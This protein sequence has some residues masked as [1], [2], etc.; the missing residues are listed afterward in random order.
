MSKF[1]LSAYTGSLGF[2]TLLMLAAG[3][4]TVFSFAP[5]HLWLLQ[6]AGPALLFILLLRHDAARLTSGRAFLLGWAYGFAALYAATHWLL[7]A[8]HRFGGMP[9]LLAVIA[10]AFLAAYLALFYGLFAASA[11]WVGRR[12]HPPRWI[13]ALLF[14]P[15]LWVANEW[16]RGFLFTGFPWAISG[17]AH[18]AS[19]LA[20]FAPVLGVLGLGWL[21]GVLAGMAALLFLNPDR[22]IRFAV[23]LAVTGVLAAG[24]WLQSVSWTSPSGQPLKISLLQGNI[25]QD[26][27][28]DPD[29]LEATLRLYHDMILQANADLIVTPETALPVLSSQLPPDYLPTLNAFA[30]QQRHA[31]LIGLAAHDG[32]AR[33]ANSVVGFSP[34]YAQ[35]AYRYDKHHLVPFGEF[36]P[37]GFRWFVN[38]MHIPLG[39]FTAGAPLQAAMH[40]RDQAVL[41]N[42]C[43]EDL[44]GE[45]IAAQLAAQADGAGAATILLNVSN[46]AWYGDSV[47]MP[48]HLQFS[49]MRVLETGRPMLRS[50]NTGATAAIDAGG[51]Q[52]AL[53]PYLERGILSATVQGRQGITP[54]IRW[55]NQLI[56]GLALLSLLTGFALTIRRRPAADFNR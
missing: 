32:D 19:P 45:E 18:T 15:A 42:I 9:E 37:Y 43:Y 4:L 28:F 35:W 24:S 13:A 49:I 10:L 29:H 38:L 23:P 44:F 5:F 48:Q 25:A 36:I 7:I 54:Y 52:I 12:W 50:T 22:V 53:L 33:Y 6:V 27:K 2:S 39:D 1:S 26:Q 20:G 31:V 3:G 41:P 8:M 16:L 56:A 17:Y 14:F 40:V 55:G 21:N 46:M 11:C 47:A 51:R 34:D 30:Q